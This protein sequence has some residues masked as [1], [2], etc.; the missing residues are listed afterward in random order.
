MQIESRR[1]KETKEEYAESLAR[2]YI[3]ALANGV[4]KL[5]YVACPKRGS[6]KRR[7]EGQR[8]E[9]SHLLRP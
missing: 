8:G 4:E 2:S 5:F 9:E 6:P 3:F 7:R 1:D